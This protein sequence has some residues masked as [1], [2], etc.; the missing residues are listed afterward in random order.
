MKNIVFIT[1][2]ILFFLYE[3]GY[4]QDQKNKKPNVIRGAFLQS[5]STNRIVIRWRTDIACNSYVRYGSLTSILTHV[6]ADS[7]LVT[8]HIVTVVGLKPYKKYYYSVGTEKQTLQT[9]P[10]NYFTTFPLPGT[11]GSYRIAAVGD[12]GNNS[13]NQRQVRDQLIKYVGNR[14]L[15]AWILLGD[16]AYS[17]GRDAEFQSNFF[18]IYKDNLLPKYSLFPSPGNHDYKDG[19]PVD[20]ASAQITHKM[21]YFRNFTLPVNGESGGVSS[22]NPAFYSF[23]LGNI[24]FLSLDSYGKEEKKYR[25]S[26]TLGPQVQWIKKDLEA[27]KNKGWII[28]YWHHPPFTMGSHN[29]DEEE[30]LVHIRENFIRILERYGVDLILCGHSHDYERSKLMQGYYGMEKEFDASKYLVNT[31]SG[32]Y[33]GSANSCPFLKNSASGYKGTVYVVSGS[34]GQ[35]GGQQSTFPHDAM[36]YSNADNGGVSMLEINDNRLDLKWLCAD[37]QIRDHFTMMKEVN[38]D[39]TIHVKKG[40]TA[41][42]TASYI[43]KYFWSSG[44]AHS[45]SIKVNPVSSTIYEVTDNLNCVKDR[46]D[47]KID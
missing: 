38:R 22:H 44:N 4:S 8:D 2:A 15:D 13:V 17:S 25:L 47:V 7:Q 28:A 46:F 39:T 32:F 20:E 37:G 45:R 12:C 5:A 24:H 21:A 18:N 11:I 26:D 3:P 30:E 36:P 27:N 29:S 9:G 43:G 1:C 34:A 31:S 19:D 41:T 33:D 23:D 16:N 35:L 14:N 6:V 10:N 40:R 42:L